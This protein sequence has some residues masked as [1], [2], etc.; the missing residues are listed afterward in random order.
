MEIVYDKNRRIT[1]YSNYLHTE[2]KELF[3]TMFSKYKYKIEYNG[4]YNKNTLENFGKQYCS[5]SLIYEG[6]F[7]NNYY[8]GKGILYK[9]K[10]KIYEGYFK[11]GKYDGIGIEYLPN[12]KRERKMKYSNGKALSKCMGVLY[13]NN[14]KPIYAGLLINGIAEEG[15]D[16]IIYD[17][18]N[19]IIY[20]KDIIFFKFN[21]NKM[22]YKN[23]I[24]NE[25][26]L[27]I[28]IINTLDYEKDLRIKTCFAG[29]GCSGITNVI[30]RLAG[31]VY[32]EC[33]LATAGIDYCSILYEYNKI[34]VRILLYDSGSQYIFRPLVK[35]NCRNA[36]II[37][38]IFDLSYMKL[39]D[40]S[41]INELRAILNSNKKLIYLVGN[42]CDKYC[43]ILLNHREKAKEFINRGIINKYFEVSEK[44]EKEY[45]SY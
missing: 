5:K 27:V 33:S 16:I 30:R 10:Q 2:Y 21:E 8:N 28:D 1:K 41:Y 31:E 13:D 45:M 4:Y 22:L 35:Q 39:L 38:F 23:Y 25:Q 11:N 18:I 42:Q 29:V 3:F 32:E 37:I 40:D 17:E 43:N 26:K 20:K 7:N 34:K 12:G 15:K 24:Y 9:D 14:D 6:F 36:D 19:N 44:R